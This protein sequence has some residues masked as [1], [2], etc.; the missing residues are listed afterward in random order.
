MKL[1]INKGKTFGKG[2]KEEKRKDQ[3]PNK[4]LYL[5]VQ[6]EQGGVLRGKNTKP[7]T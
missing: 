1:Q 3:S 4:R 2:R 6:D 7:R 5:K